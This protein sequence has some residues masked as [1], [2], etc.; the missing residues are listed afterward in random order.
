MLVWNEADAI[1][2]LETLP[3]IDEDAVSYGFTIVRD[4]LR[5]ELTVFPY[6]SDVCISLFRDGVAEPV[7]DVTLLDCGGMRHVTD[8]SSERLEFAPAKCFGSR[9]DGRSPPP[10]GVSVAVKPSIQLRLFSYP[11]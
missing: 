2:C 8:Q 11:A 9:Y 4:G 1:A 5:L 6:A 3:E 7:F 10:Y